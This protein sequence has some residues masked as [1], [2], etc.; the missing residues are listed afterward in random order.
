MQHRPRVRCWFSPRRRLSGED[1]LLQSNSSSRVSGLNVCMIFEC[2]RSVSGA[3]AAR[4]VA[5]W[6]DPG[7][8]SLMDTGNGSE[9]QQH[10]RQVPYLRWVSRIRCSR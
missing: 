5:G 6:A 1:L 8:A 3:Q 9:G 4:L 2:D 10:L 7:K